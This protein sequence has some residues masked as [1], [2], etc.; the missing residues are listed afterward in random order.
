MSTPTTS[1]PSLEVS[2]PQDRLPERPCPAC[3]ASTLRAFYAAGS[4]SAESSPHI[5]LAQCETCAFITNAAINDLSLAAHHEPGAA[6]PCDSIRQAAADWADR[7]DLHGKTLI[8]IACGDGLFLEQLCT[9]ADARGIGFDPCVRHERSSTADTIFVAGAFEDFTGQVHGDFIFCRHALERSAEP[10]RLVSALRRFADQTPVICEVRDIAGTLADGAFWEI[11]P[12]QHGFFTTASL[13]R[14]FQRAGFEVTQTHRAISPGE[15]RSSILLEA[16][17][18]PVGGQ[19]RDM[20]TLA[21]L[22]HVTHFARLARRHL[23]R[24]CTEE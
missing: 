15:R 22:R 7:F 21:E 17:A 8:D 16:V 18:E 20:P 12:G 19:K 1:G 14:L 10:L 11:E 6:A 9:T 5:V 24:P 2:F 13:T 23:T 4:D 3:G